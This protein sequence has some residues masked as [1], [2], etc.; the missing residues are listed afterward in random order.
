MEAPEL[1]PSPSACFH[2][3]PLSARSSTYLYSAL[4]YDCA[5]TTTP[6]SNFTP[7]QD[8]APVKESN[9]AAGMKECGSDCKDAADSSESAAL[10]MDEV[11][12]RDGSTVSADSIRSS[13]LL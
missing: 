5:S 13:E 6:G 7:P 9:S 2:S 1:P 10:Y 12:I 11:K 3:T 8:A 4:Q